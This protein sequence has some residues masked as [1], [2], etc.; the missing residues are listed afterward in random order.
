MIYNVKNRYASGVSLWRVDETKFQITN[1]DKLPILITGNDY[2]LIRKEYSTVFET[3][4]KEEIEILNVIIFRKATS[5]TWDNYCEL[6]IKNHINPDNINLADYLHDSVW[7]FEHNLFVNSEIK[8]ELEKLVK[9]KL[10][11][12]E[13]FSHFG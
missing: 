4:L 11:F 13:N 9:G 1:Y 10:V 5:E 12:S 2:T 3:L 8:E 6:K 7:Q